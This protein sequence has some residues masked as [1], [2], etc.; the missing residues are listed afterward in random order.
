MG[1]A[2]PFSTVICFMVLRIIPPNLR[3]MSKIIRRVKVVMFP[4]LHPGIILASKLLRHI[5]T[6][7]ELARLEG[8]R[9]SPYPSDLVQAYLGKFQSSGERENMGYT[10][11]N[12]S[13]CLMMI[14]HQNQP[15]IWNTK[16]M[17]AAKS[18]SKG[19]PDR[20]MWNQALGAYGGHG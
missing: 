19:Q 13:N 5:Q 6:L 18:F 14:H 15:Y 7:V 4:H 16:I 17:T 12:R 1:Q 3:P 9:G 11:S 2:L 10:W 20:H 8:W